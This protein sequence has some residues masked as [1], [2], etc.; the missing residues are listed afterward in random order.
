MRELQSWRKWGTNQHRISMC[1]TLEHMLTEDLAPTLMLEK[2]QALQQEWKLLNK[3]GNRINEA[4]WQRFN[5]AADQIYAKCRPYLDEQNNMRELSRKARES[6]CQQVELFAKA[7]DW[8]Q[9]NWKKVIHAVREVRATW[10]KLGAVDPRQQKSLNQ[11]YH[12]AMRM[13]ER[14]ISQERAKN[15]ALR[16]TL[17]EKAQTQAQNPDLIKAIKEIRQ[18][19]EQWHI[20]VASKRNQEDS[21]WKAFR[22]ACDQV[23]ER[24]RGALQHQQEVIESQIKSLGVPG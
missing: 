12:A 4:L 10:E 9:V 17:I 8:S 5:T 23:F 16:Q 20:T 15:K 22:T 2:V 24:R 1:E 19:Q 6:L 18:L 3:E 7:V 14:P 13:L 11:R 21:L